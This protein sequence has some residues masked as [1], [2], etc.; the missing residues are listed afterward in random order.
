MSLAIV[1]CRITDIEHWRK[2]IEKA[3]HEVCGEISVLQVR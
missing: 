1:S 2:Q 3:L